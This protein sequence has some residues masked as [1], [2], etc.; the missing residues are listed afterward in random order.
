MH[1]HETE[2]ILLWRKCPIKDYPIRYND[3][4]NI[5]CRIIVQNERDMV[6]INVNKTIYDQVLKQIDVKKNSR[7]YFTVSTIMYHC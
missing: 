1:A 3:S 2:E 6:S 7:L 4:I 5:N